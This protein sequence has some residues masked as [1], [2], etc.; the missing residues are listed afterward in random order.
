L[1]DT[2]EDETAP[3]RIRAVLA[4]ATVWSRRRPLAIGCYSGAWMPVRGASSGAESADTDAWAALTSPARDSE[5]WDTRFSPT[6][7]QLLPLH[8][9]ALHCCGCSA[10]VAPPGSVSRITKRRAPRRYDLAAF[11]SDVDPSVVHCARR[12][13]LHAKMAEAVA[14]APIIAEW[15]QCGGCGAII[16]YEETQGGVARLIDLQLPLLRRRYKL[17]L[18]QAGV[19]LLRAEPADAWAACA[20][21]MEPR[22]SG[23]KNNIERAVALA[24]ACE[25]PGGAGGGEE[26]AGPDTKPRT[27]AILAGNARMIGAD[28]VARSLRP[29]EQPAHGLTAKNPSSSASPLDHVLDGSK[30]AFQSPFI[31]TTASFPLAVVWALPF[32]PLCVVNVG[33]ATATG[34]RFVTDLECTPGRTEEERSKAV[35]RMRRDAERLIERGV[36]ASAVDVVHSRVDACTPVACAVTA[37]GVTPTATG[38]G[39][40]GVGG[41]AA[42]SG[43]GS[44]DGAGSAAAAVVVPF[45]FP[46]DVAE[47]RSLRLVHASMG[48]SD[49][50]VHLLERADGARR[51]AVLTTAP[52][53][54]P[55]AGSLTVAQLADLGMEQMR[56]VVAFAARQSPLLPVVVY[57]LTI[58]VWVERKACA[59]AVES[60]QSPV[61]LPVLL[62]DVTG[63]PDTV[64]TPTGPLDHE[65]AP[66][67]APPASGVAAGDGA[68][69]RQAAMSPLAALIAALRHVLKP[70]SRI[71]LSPV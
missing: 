18:T 55:I 17:Y 42:G 62:V 21:L 16:G 35:A 12:T 8:A 23:P 64:T 25:E 26:A 59:A 67:A 29:S 5:P 30:P 11:A 63:V 45:G 1:F 32:N 37:S 20:A 19:S 70:E 33:A 43:S 61:S 15:V 46:R 28:T 2:E 50:N 44:A 65:A 14:T 41:G 3:A 69:P 7:E 31:S 9:I 66:A 54:S 60:I 38:D 53:G 24:H 6:A 4:A 58:D 57:Q 68:V 34:C 52:N 49:A 27:V 47:F 36:S 56:R 10:L 48:G 71:A 40:G 51:F 22:A 13:P 39:A